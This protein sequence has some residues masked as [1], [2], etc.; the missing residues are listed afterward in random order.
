MGG[1]AEERE[2]EAKEGEGA[3]RCP[4]RGLEE[5]PECISLLSFSSFNLC[6]FPLPLIAPCYYRTQTFFLGVC[7][8]FTV[9]LLVGANTH[10]QPLFSVIFS[11]RPGLSV[12]QLEMRD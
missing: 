1:E 6:N 3:K 12:W 8:G 9:H 4:K 10:T 11:L 7:V 2:G 5:G